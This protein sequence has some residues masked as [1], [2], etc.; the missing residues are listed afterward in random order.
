MRAPGGLRVVMVT[1]STRPAQADLMPSMPAM[2]PEGR[3]RRQPV[4]RAR[5]ITWGC[6][7]SAPVLITSRS[8]PAPKAFSA[9]IGTSSPP[10]ASI[11]RPARS[12]RAS[13]GSQGGGWGRVSRKAVALSRSRLVTPATFTASRPSPTARRMARPMAPQPTIPMEFLP[14]TSPAV[15]SLP[16]D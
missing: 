5:S 15:E 2:A 4:S 9:S 10:A 11:T 1:C 6:S 3:I 8:F 13:K 16:G 14:L 12:M 7:S